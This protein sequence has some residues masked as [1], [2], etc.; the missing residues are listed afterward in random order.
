MKLVK[1][2]LIK[3]NICSGINSETFNLAGIKV[4]PR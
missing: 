1:L 4:M 2:N 3:T